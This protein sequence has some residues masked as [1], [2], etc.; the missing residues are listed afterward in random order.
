MRELQPVI[1][2]FL[3]GMCACCVSRTVVWYISHKRQWLL[4]LCK[5][6]AAPNALQESCDSLLAQA[7]LLEAQIAELRK[8]PCRAQPTALLARI[9]GDSSVHI[10][11]PV[12]AAYGHSN[13]GLNAAVP[14]GA[15]ARRTH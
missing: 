7:S 3:L 15:L 2:L 11:R 6:R 12:H 13:I 10:C 4:T 8:L 5:G 14:R 9:G 1:V